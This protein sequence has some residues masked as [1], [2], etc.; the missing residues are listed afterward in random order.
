MSD[1]GIYG[2]RL[3]K[4]FHL[5]AATAFVSQRFLMA[6]NAVTEIK[7]DVAKAGKIGSCTGARRADQYVIRRFGRYWGVATS[8]WLPK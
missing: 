3:A 5:E 1:R 6:E 2:E 4:V 7:C 8:C